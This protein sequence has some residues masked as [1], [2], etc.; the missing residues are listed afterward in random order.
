[1]DANTH[2]KLLLP[3]VRQIRQVILSVR[4]FN[5]RAAKQTVKCAPPQVFPGSAP[6]TAA[7]WRI[8]EGSSSAA[9]RTYPSYPFAA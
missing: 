1:M 2:I 9:A 8:L 4:Y 5:Q 6:P 3:P 7:T